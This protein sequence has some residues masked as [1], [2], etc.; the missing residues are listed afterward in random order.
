MNRL[1]IRA[2]WIVL[3]AWCSGFDG[4]ALLARPV[5]GEPAVDDAVVA[6]PKSVETATGSRT[7][8]SF[9]V[10]APA[11][12]PF[13][14]DAELFSSATR[15][16]GS[17]VLLV[18]LI[19]MGSFLLKRYWPGRF[20]AVPGE[21]HI[22]VIETVALGERQSLT[23]VQVGQ[24]RLLLARTAGSITLLD[25]AEV[26]TEAVVDTAMEM[27][28]EGQK[29]N[30][31]ELIGVK[32]GAL[33]L[34]RQIEARF[35]AGLVRVKATLSPFFQKPRDIP[36]GK[37]PSFEQIMQGELSAT[38]LS[39]TRTGSAARSRLSEI[40]NRLQAE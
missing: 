35:K 34:F 17:V 6:S 21:R 31:T 39:S 10:S 29:N 33:S 37:S 4:A 20:G 13:R 1:L 18:G 14:G 25:R 23:L 40:R 15:A 27:P 5:S 26:T 16:T 32:T 24:S 19:L 38:T 36:N 30:G 12:M 22:D 3:A 8:L 9:P 7:G 11:E 28:V 2:A